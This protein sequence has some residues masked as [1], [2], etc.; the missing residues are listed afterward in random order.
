MTVWMPISAKTLFSLGIIYN[1]TAKLES[2]LQPRPGV[3]CLELQGA[4]RSHPKQKGLLKQ[5]F[6][7]MN[8]DLSN[9]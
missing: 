2:W 9:P 4:Q 8:P 3:S 7:L 6:V 5:V 1:F